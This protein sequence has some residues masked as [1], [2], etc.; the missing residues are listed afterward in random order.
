MFIFTFGWSSCTFCQKCYGVRERILLRKVEGK[1]STSGMSS[2]VAQLR[3]LRFLPVSL[4]EVWVVP[5]QLVHCTIETAAV[6]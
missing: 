5:Q 3:A 1:R 2:S 4:H 6:L